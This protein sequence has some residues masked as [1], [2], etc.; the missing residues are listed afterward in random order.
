[1]QDMEGLYRSLTFPLKYEFY[2]PVTNREISHLDCKQHAFKFN[3]VIKCIPSFNFEL[4]IV[5]RK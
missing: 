5:F 4:G 3:T 2:M 1:M